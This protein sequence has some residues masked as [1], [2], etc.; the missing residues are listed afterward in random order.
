MKT[1]WGA[2]GAACLFFFVL[3]GA[4]AAPHA[5]P[6]P[7]PRRLPPSALYG[8]A[9]RRSAQ[10]YLRLKLLELREEDLDRAR[11]VIEGKLGVGVLLATPPPL[12]KDAAERNK[13]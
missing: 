12:L 11:L 3:P 9:V 8:P 1:R 6:A 10:T 4:K 13:P 7:K 2:L 5:T